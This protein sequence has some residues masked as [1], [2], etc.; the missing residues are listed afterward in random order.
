MK[1]CALNCIIPAP[2]SVKISE[3][4][5]FPLRELKKVHAPTSLTRFGAEAQ[6]MLSGFGIA[7]AAGP[8]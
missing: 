5:S 3:M 4:G 8:G 6:E 1:E 2:V 7:A